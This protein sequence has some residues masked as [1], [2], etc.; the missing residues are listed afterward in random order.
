MSSMA[1]H[2]CFGTYKQFPSPLTANLEGEVWG[3]GLVVGDTAYLTQH[4]RCDPLDCITVGASVIA[5]RRI[6]KVLCCGARD[7]WLTCA[8]IPSAD[9]SAMQ[10]VSSWHRTGNALVAEGKHGT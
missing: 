9:D 8:K 1:S 10:R 3:G 6:L 5:L 7:D 2:G 4:T